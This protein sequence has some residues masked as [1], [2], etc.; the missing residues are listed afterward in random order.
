MIG[1]Y[2]L[3]GGMILFVSIIGTMDLIAR[4][5]D[6]LEREERKRRKQAA[7]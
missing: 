4:R 1:L 3:F 7:G 6:R 5:Q 2:V